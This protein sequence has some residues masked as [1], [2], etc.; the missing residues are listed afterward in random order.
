MTDR[1]A[2]AH[3]ASYCPMASMTSASSTSVT[4][5]SPTSLPSSTTGNAPIFAAASQPADLGDEVLGMR[6]LGR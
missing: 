3:A 2:E 4:V 1:A 6:G 5:M